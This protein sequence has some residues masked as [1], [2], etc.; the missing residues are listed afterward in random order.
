MMV[1]PAPDDD[2]DFPRVSELTVAQRYGVGREDFDAARTFALAA[3]R[4]GAVYE[5]TLPAGTIL[6]HMGR[7]YVL[8]EPTR[9]RSPLP[10]T[11]V[12][13]EVPEGAPPTKDIS[14]RMVKPEPVARRTCALVYMHAEGMI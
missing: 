6:E 9:V 5:L 2:L 8:Q 10:H 3:E 13:G 4:A 11:V 1:E 7:R 12:E 14:M